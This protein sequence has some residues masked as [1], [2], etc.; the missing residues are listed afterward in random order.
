MY[1]TV[2]VFTTPFWLSIF[3]ELHRFYTTIFSFL[4]RFVAEV[5]DTPG[6]S[7]IDQRGDTTTRCRNVL[8]TVLQIDNHQIC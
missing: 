3:S 4:M 2:I 5:L 7:N 6:I 8:E 1:C